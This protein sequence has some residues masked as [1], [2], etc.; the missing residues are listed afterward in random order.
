MT[1]WGSAAAVVSL[2]AV[3]GLGIV[4]ERPSSN[5]VPAPVSA[6]EETFEDQLTSAYALVEDKKWDQSADLFAK[7]IEQDPRNRAAT[8]GLYRAKAQLRI[9]QGGADEIEGLING[10]MTPEL[11]SFVGYLRALN[12]E[13]N[14]AIAMM[15]YAQRSGQSGEPL[16]MNLA[17][18]L[19]Q[20]GDLDEAAAIL[21]EIRRRF[22]DREKANLLLVQVIQNRDVVNGGMSIEEANALIEAVPE[23]GNRY[24]IQSFVYLKCGFKARRNVELSRTYFA[25]S[26]EL[27]VEACRRGEDL[28][29]WNNIRSLLP[30]DIRE[31]HAEFF[32][33][34]G[35]ESAFPDS[36]DFTIDPLTGFRLQQ[37]IKVT[38][39]QVQQPIVVAGQ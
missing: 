26:A 6:I 31:Q 19:N 33:K 25:R 20:V 21:E 37:I 27:M 18:C 12:G 17:Y 39:D 36:R 32:S 16:L 24:R 28:R 9:S 14:M 11:A 5:P 23:T 30:K 3:I 2:G 13:F 38:A 15:R 22:G 1:R 4:E 35:T 34:S 7:V 8:I 10:N 29:N